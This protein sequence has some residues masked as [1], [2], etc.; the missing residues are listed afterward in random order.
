MLILIWILS[1][2]VQGQ[3]VNATNNSSGSGSINNWSWSAPNTTPSSATGSTPPTFN[4]ATQGS[5][6]I[7]LTITDI[8][9]C[10][11]DTT[12][13]VEV[14]DLNVVAS[15]SS[16]NLTCFNPQVQLYFQ[17]PPVLMDFPVSSI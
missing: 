3:G 12:I 13:N 17:T 1:T 8:A 14:Y 9:G 16:M 15:A 5:H 4:F 2:F 6:P 11:D 10:V 7:T